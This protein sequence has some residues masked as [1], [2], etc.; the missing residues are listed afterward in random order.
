MD[1]SGREA[2][3]GANVYMET[4][5]THA[6]SNSSHMKGPLCGGPATLQ[7]VSFPRPLNSNRAPNSPRARC[8]EISCSKWKQ[9]RQAFHLIAHPSV[10][11]PETVTIDFEIPMEK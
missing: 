7:M 3:T 9:I 1:A 2:M 8:V 5:Q 6:V 11:F 4:I 10:Y